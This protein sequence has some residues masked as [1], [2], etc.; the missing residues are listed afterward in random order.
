MPRVA[1]QCR[2]LPGVKHCTHPRRT[3]SAVERCCMTASHRGGLLASGPKSSI[4]PTTGMATKAA[5]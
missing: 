1:S 4:A 5:K 2:H 3:R